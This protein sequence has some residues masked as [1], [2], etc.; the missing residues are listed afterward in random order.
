M[1]YLY[2]IFAEFLAKHHFTEIIAMITF[3][4]IPFCVIA[5][6][7]MVA[8]IA[9]VL[10]ERKLL[11]FFTQIKGPNRVGF[12]GVFQTIADAIKLLCKEDI[13]PSCADKFL[14]TIAPLISFI[15]VMIVW[16]LIPFCSEFDFMSYS[17]SALLFLSIGAIPIL[18][19]LL[20][21]YASNNKYSLLGSM[22][23]VVQAI[24][25]ELPLIFVLVSV[26]VLASSMNLKQIVLAQTSVYPFCG[27]NIFPSFLGF[28]DRKS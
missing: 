8:V 6:V 10:A 16:G 12:W 3:P 5:A 13:I 28:I 26:V 21:G 7:M 23:S 18:G 4:I 15:P 17:V 19:N 14:F 2:F 24:S 20:A 11:G 27:W 22:R 1:E 25:Y 9:L